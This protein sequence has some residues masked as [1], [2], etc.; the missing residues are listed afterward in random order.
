MFRI[1]NEPEDREAPDFDGGGTIFAGG[2]QPDDGIFGFLQPSFE[3]DDGHDV[4]IGDDEAVSEPLSPPPAVPLAGARPDEDE[5]P[6]APRR[7]FRRAAREA[8]EQTAPPSMAGA[9]PSPLSVEPP[10]RPAAPAS[11]KA[12]RVAAVDA[13]E[14]EDPAALGAIVADYLGRP[15]IDIPERIELCRALAAPALKSEAAR[16]VWLKLFRELDRRV[17]ASPE[18]TTAGLRALSP[19]LRASVLWSLGAEERSQAARLLTAINPYSAIAKAL[20][21]DDRDRLALFPLLYGDREALDRTIRL[22]A[23]RRR[24]GRV[25]TLAMKKVR[26]GVLHLDQVIAV[27]ELLGKDDRF[28]AGMIAAITTSRLFDTAMRLFVDRDAPLATASS[29]G[30]LVERLYEAGE[31]PLIERVLTRLAVAE[32]GAGCAAATAAAAG[33]LGL[34]TLALARTV[35][36]TGAVLPAETALVLHRDLLAAGHA[37]EARAV[38][39]THVE[40]DADAAH[41]SCKLAERYDTPEIA[42]EQWRQAQAR[43]PEPRFKAGV[44]RSLAAALRL[45]AA[46][47]TLWGLVDTYPDRSGYWRDLSR[48]FQEVGDWESWGSCLAEARRDLPED[49]WVAHAVR[50]SESERGRT[51]TIDDDP[52]TVLDDVPSAR[53]LAQRFV[54]EGRVAE[55]VDLRHA[56]LQ[57]TRERRDHHHYV[58][59][60]FQAGRFNDAAAELERCIARFPGEAH[61]HVKRG[62][63]RERRLEWA[64]A[65]EAYAQAK[66][67]D[68][69]N[70]EAAPGV[71]RCL[72]YLGRYESLETWLRR[73][74]A[75]DIRFGWV[76]ALRAFGAA[77]AGRP[78]D[79]QAALDPLY[80]LFQGL[81]EEY[82]AAM[83]Q[84]PATVWTPDGARVHPL[85]R[86][87]KCNARFLD[88]LEG[89]ARARNVVLVGNA[90]S[91]LGAGLGDAID[92][93]DCVIRLNDFRT[94]GF[95]AD[96]GTRTSVWYTRAHR[97]ARPDPAGLSGADIVAQVDT[98]NQ[99]PP[100]DEY[101]TGRLRVAIPFERATVLP[102]YAL[103]AT[104]AATY[105]KP[106]TGFRIIQLLE[107]FLQRDYD[108]AG[109]SFFKGAGMHYFDGD[110]QRLQ[111]G[112]MHAIDFEKDFVERVLCEGR[113]MTRL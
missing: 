28:L 4:R 59:T 29:L 48:A 15:G 71:A 83:R 16:P 79:A 37:A 100:M 11:P 9:S 27:H 106:T 69:D 65:L 108:I 5:T 90:P 32:G 91:I 110:E 74:P 98:L 52:A 35:A 7:S 92:A 94:G 84:Q 93:H 46:E 101:L 43:W 113:H 112:E 78:S 99:Y 96:V 24:I 87:G 77:M 70:A 68:P 64:A 104:D 103:M 105:T 25:A 60:L 56:V 34:P 30:A 72:A 82:E 18:S 33:R 6:P 75:D 81:R 21:E 61:L 13:A 40:T 26:D 1:L 53:M 39:V 47:D 54:I 22:A 67:L 57:R 97:L 20:S 80:E 17:A 2:D 50:W 36:R 88:I 38:L 8:Q 51:V 42:L 76:H 12:L 63:V 45:E 107:F 14:R 66:A 31:L 89:I 95:E 109:F 85:E 23:Q 49:P 86:A 3:D 55:A 102:S 62:Q 41:G 44:G 73:F 111:V 10:Q 19:A 58:L